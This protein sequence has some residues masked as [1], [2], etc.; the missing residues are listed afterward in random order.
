ML[1]T[2]EK[3]TMILGRQSSFCP[4]FVLSTQER[5]GVKVEIIDTFTIL[6]QEGVK[7]KVLEHIHVP[8]T[9]ISKVHAVWIKVELKYV[10]QENWIGEVMTYPCVSKSKAVL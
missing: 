4:D 1:E 9:W 10:S 8:V 6:V 2:P 3:L 7:V 5:G